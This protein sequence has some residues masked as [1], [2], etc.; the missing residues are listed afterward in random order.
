MLIRS[1]REED[2]METIQQLNAKL[3]IKKN[4]GV[5]TYY[6]G[7]SIEKFKSGT[8]AIN[9]RNKIEEI[10]IVQIFEL[11][12]EKPTY[13]PMETNYC[14]LETEDDLL[15]DNTQY[16]QAVGALLYIATIS[17]PN[18]ACSVNLLSR[19]NEKPRNIDWN[20]VKKVIRYT[21]IQLKA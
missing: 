21:Y 15:E 9:Q 8:F 13:T 6:L 16:R 1:E 2:V 3:E 5:V 17:R 7:I 12:N 20:A 4:L 11:Q 18:I 19:R 10:S 14:K